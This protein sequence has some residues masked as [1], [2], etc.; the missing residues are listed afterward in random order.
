MRSQE[1][2]RRRSYEVSLE[3]LAVGPAGVQS[4]DNY[5][6]RGE[7]MLLFVENTA[8][9]FYFASYESQEKAELL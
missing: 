2:F 3:I 6:R 9:K 1:S 8:R 5:N 7:D 4:R